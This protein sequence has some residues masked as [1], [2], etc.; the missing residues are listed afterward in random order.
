M[1]PGRLYALISTADPK[2]HSRAIGGRLYAIKRARNITSARGFVDQ[3]EAASISRG[4]ASQRMSSIKGMK[5]WSKGDVPV[6][7]ACRDVF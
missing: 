4:A 6:L 7:M 1:T 2:S 5:D 3:A